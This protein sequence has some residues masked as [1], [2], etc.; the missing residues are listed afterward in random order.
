[1]DAI[2]IIVAN[3]DNIYPLFAANVKKERCGLL[4]VKGKKLRC[5]EVKNRHKQPAERFRIMRADLDA[6]KERGERLVGVLHTHW[7]PGGAEPSV[8]DVHGLPDGLL[9]L[10]I[11]PR[12]SSWTLYDNAVG[13]LAFY[14]GV[15]KRSNIIEENT[16]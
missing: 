11:H 14:D 7:K 3:M 16:K 5:V 12:T 13:V 15:A 2:D 4:L 8:D 1:M 10:V 6:H 9:G